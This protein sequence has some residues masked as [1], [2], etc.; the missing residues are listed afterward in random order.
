MCFFFHFFLK[1]QAILL[2]KK[3]NRNVGFFFHF[4]FFCN[5]FRNKSSESVPILLRITN[6]ICARGNHRPSTGGGGDV[7]PLE[8]GGEV[9][10]WNQGGWPAPGRDDKLFL[11]AVFIP[12]P[13]WRCRVVAALYACAQKFWGRTSS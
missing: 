9:P 4:L 7:P 2:M 1:S 11:S 5:S 12:P 10:S 8:L 6:K 3:I 13:P